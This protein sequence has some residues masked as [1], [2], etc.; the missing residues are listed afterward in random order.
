MQR[1]TWHRRNEVGGALAAA[2][3][4]FLLDKR[5]IF[6]SSRRTAFV[7]GAIDFSSWVRTVAVIKAVTTSSTDVFLGIGIVLSFPLKRQYIKTR[8]EG[9]SAC[10][11]APRSQTPA[12]P[13]H[14]APGVPRPIVV[15]YSSFSC[16]FIGITKREEAIRQRFHYRNAVEAEFPLSNT[17]IL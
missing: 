8:C 13:W 7:S 17:R 11:A 14:T 2:F 3:L 9:E 15:G 10:Q 1:A 5:S 6:R 4:G 12:P 16:F